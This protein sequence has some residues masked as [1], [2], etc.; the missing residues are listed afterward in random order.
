MRPFPSHSRF[1][2]LFLSTFVSLA[3]AQPRAALGQSSPKPHF[4]EQL[5]KGPQP[6]DQ[7]H[8]ISYW[9]TEPGWNTELLLRNNLES[10]ELTVVP[11]LRTANGAETALPS[12][13]I[14]PGD[15]ASLDLYDTLMK[16]APQLAGAWGSLVVRFHAIA[17]S[18]LYASVMVRA[19][20]RP[21]VFHLDGFLRGTKYDVGS[22]EGIW[23]LP[24][25]SVTGYL[26]LT[27]SGD[28]QLQPNLVL[29]DSTGKGWQQQL[30]LSARQT[31]RLSMRSLLQQAGFSGSFGGIKLDVAKGARYLDSAHL[32]FDESGGFSAIMKMFRHDPSTTI[33]SRS[34]G[35][36][37]EWTTR[38]PMLA[39][40]NP[41]PALAFPTGTTLQPKV[42]VRNSSGKTVTAHLAFNWRSATTSGKSAPLNLA[43]KPNES[44]VIDVAAL[45]AQGLLPNDAQWAS[46]VLSASVLP[47]ELLAVAAT[48]DQTGRYGTQTPFSDQLAS[49]WEGGMW[50]ADRTHNSLV[51]VVNGGST[52]SRAQLTILY[53][54]GAGQYQVEQPLSPG[55]QM[56]IDFGK[57]IH[58]QVP[59]KNGQTLP[60]GL[61]EG[62][63]RLLDLNDNPLGN[64]YEGRLIVDKTYG[65]AAYNCMICCGPNNPW[66][67]YDPLSVFIN[68]FEDQG[69]LA[70]NSCSE[71]Q[72]TV[73]SDFP[74]WWTD[75]T[76]IAT[77]SGYK[78]TGVAI[79]TTNNNAESINMY[80]G[81]KTDSGGGSCPLSQ[82]EPSAP[83]NVT[84]SITSISPAQGL[85]G[86]AESVTIT[87]T[88]FASGA[89]VNAG[90]NISVSNTTVVSSTTITATFT[91]TNST[92]AGGNQ[93][94]TVTV[95]GVPP[96]NSINFYVQIPTHLAR[97]SFSGVF[98]AGPVTNGIGPL[99]TGTNI[100]FYYPNGTVYN[101][102][103]NECGGYQWFTYDVVIC[104]LAPRTGS[105]D[106]KTS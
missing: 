88:G 99:V 87:G 51:T 94:V 47:D 6:V 98:P 25:S 43:F 50:E 14:K 28:Q 30:S 49:H 96:S 81:P 20:G 33:S 53:N 19:S 31:L 65:H 97:I 13:T 66:M 10:K 67:T 37:K 26:I 68:D 74:T 22:R 77:A 101:S 27:N 38:A 75:N 69:I 9:T 56:A 100:T 58:N 24:W 11:A 103:T 21:I 80:W 61:T 85:V 62:T 15:V 90:T 48:Y 78:I 72:V 35:G 3:L 4:P 42:F 82:Q 83:T 71:R 46:V 104:P 59:D 32:L 18:A 1:A 29:Y 34:F 7:E 41:D 16:A 91:P 8:F 54:Q 95:S 89:T 17:P 5:A 44:Q 92:S 79:G 52:P 57:L 23:W 76:S 105:Y 60:P 70:I 63:Y 12:L 102:L 55:E 73:T 45:Q 86:T 2:V 39:L 93:G 84:P 106:T 36:V 64:L 40:S